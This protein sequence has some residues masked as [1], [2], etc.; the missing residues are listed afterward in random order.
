MQGAVLLTLTTFPVRFITKEK[1]LTVSRMFSRMKRRACF[2]RA[3]GGGVSALEI[4][5]SDSGWLVHLH[6]LMERKAPLSKNW[7]KTTWQS[8]GGGQQVDIDPIE[9]RATMRTLSYLLKY[10]LDSDLI[11]SD[12]DHLRQYIR[13]TWGVRLFQAW[14]SAHSLHGRART[15]RVVSEVR[16]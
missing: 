15:A 16:Q 11:P 4:K 3:V 7:V 5:A 9:S 14:G 13:S 12:V 1:V 2:R 6:V 8:F 10:P